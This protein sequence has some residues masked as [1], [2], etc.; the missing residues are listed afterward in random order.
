M[1]NPAGGVAMQ[2][3]EISPSEI[4]EMKIRLQAILFSIE[5]GIVMTDF[6]GSISII[7]DSAKKFLGIKKKFPYEKKFLDYIP[8]DYVSKKIARMLESADD[9]L[10]EEIAFFVQE[11]E[12]CLRVAKSVVT[13]AKGQ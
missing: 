3:P 9:S 11:R 13:T 8:N 2:Y 4:S 7:N 1:T 10:V 6:S 12:L 5:E